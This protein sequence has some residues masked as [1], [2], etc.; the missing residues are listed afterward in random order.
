MGQLITC[1]REE[2]LME[3]VLPNIYIYGVN[4]LKFLFVQLKT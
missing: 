4:K 2:R 1:V 3:I